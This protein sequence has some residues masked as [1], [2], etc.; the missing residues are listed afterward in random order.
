MVSCARATRHKSPILF[1]SCGQCS[2]DARTIE[3]NR[4]ILLKEGAS[5]LGG[6]IIT[7][8]KDKERN[9]TA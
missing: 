4:A 5:E 6:S 9:S 2:L 1:L 8:V 3:T 7:N